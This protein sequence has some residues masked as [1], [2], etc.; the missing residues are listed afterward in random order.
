[1]DESGMSAL[2]K[3]GVAS[4]LMLSS[5]YVYTALR[6]PQGFSALEEK[7]NEIR[8]LQKVNAELRQDVEMRADRIK[9]LQESPAE[10]EL[11]IRRRLKMLR[12]GE[13]TFII[14]GKPEDKVEEKQLQPERDR[15][16][17]P[18]TTPTDPPVNPTN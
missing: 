3:I 1:M 5:I 2:S 18:P 13:T 14:P 15:S 16:V 7:W 6:G 11:E 4:V 9:K 8:E 17:T 10:Q 12:E